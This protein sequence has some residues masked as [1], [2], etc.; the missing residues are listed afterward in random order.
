MDVSAHPVDDA[1]NSILA[2]SRSST[3]KEVSQEHI[4][5]PNPSCKLSIM[6]ADKALA[7]YDA[8]DNSFTALFTQTAGA[9]AD[10][11]E[12]TTLDEIFQE[13]C[14]NSDE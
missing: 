7:G 2:Y 6:D 5:S 10:L 8:P 1:E 9:P 12:T 11:P 13:E 14:E 4:A 3:H